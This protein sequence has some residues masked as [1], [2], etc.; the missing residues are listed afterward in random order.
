MLCGVFTMKMPK[1]IP[2]LVTPGTKP[3]A[4]PRRKA[5]PKTNPS[6]LTMTSLLQSPDDIH[7]SA[8]RLAMPHAAQTSLKTVDI[9][10]DDRNDEKA[11]RRRTQKAADRRDRHR[12][13]ETGIGAISQSERQHSG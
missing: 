5:N 1:Y 4:P 2:S 6:I 3:R 7:R 12:L 9:G 13:T 8:S 11:E 10:K